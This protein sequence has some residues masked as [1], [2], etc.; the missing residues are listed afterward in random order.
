MLGAFY[1]LCGK[2][3]DPVRA[4]RVASPDR[5]ERGALKGGP[6]WD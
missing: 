3:A 5:A 2:L 6:E 1:L 4:D